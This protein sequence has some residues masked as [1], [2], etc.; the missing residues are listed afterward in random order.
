M[1]DTTKEQR[2]LNGIKKEYLNMTNCNLNFS[3]LKIHYKNEAEDYVKIPISDKGKI[4][5]KSIPK[6]CEKNYK[7]N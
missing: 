1:I 2:I 4:S 5:V 6:I 7:I 3:F